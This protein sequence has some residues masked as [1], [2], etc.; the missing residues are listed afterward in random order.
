[1]NIQLHRLA[2]PFLLTAENESGN[3]VL[4]DAAQSIGGTGKGMRPMEA[5][6]ASLAAC[7][8]MDVLSILKKKRIDIADYRVHLDAVRKDAVPAIFASMHLEFQFATSSPLAP[9]QRAVDLSMK[10]YC[11]VV[12]IVETSCTID[13]TVRRIHSTE[14]ETT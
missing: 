6:A 2:H 5:L 12:K 8:S 10:K 3:R 1:M 11:S 14:R 7:A 9:L 13:Y 4:F